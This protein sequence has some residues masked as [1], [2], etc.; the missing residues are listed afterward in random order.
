[1]TVSSLRILVALGGN[2]IL[3]REGKGTAEEQFANVRRASGHLVRLIQQGHKVTITHGNGPQVGD[4]LLKDELAKGTLPQMP[5]DVCGAE[6]Q[7]MIGYMI[8]QSLRNELRR[9]GLDLQVATV[10]TETVVDGSDPAFR[11]PT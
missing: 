3:Q 4:I 1:V 11:N 10:L 7:G 9:V 2:A 6:S 8:Q 5:L